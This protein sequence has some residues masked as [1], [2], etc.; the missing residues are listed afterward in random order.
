MTRM[1]FDVTSSPDVEV[2][3]VNVLV[4][5]R[6]PLAP[7]QEALFGRRLCGGR[8]ETMVKAEVRRVGTCTTSRVSGIQSSPRHSDD[9]RHLNRITP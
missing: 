6:L 5:R 8:G 9:S 4:G 7:Q 2:L 1:T 3:D